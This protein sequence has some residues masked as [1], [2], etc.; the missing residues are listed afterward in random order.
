ML[1]Q[2]ML[3]QT[4]LRQTMLRHSKDPASLCEAAGYI[5]KS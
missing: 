4:I 5:G 1:R 2:T 3:R